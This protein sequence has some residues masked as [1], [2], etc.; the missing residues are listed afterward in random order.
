MDKKGKVGDSVDLYN[1]TL[2]AINTTSQFNEDGFVMV[3]DMNILIKKEKENAKES[4]KSRGRIGDID[5]LPRQE[6]SLVL[7]EN[8]PGTSVFS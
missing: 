7:T 3:T 8:L 6:T 2:T 5:Y 4:L 1:D